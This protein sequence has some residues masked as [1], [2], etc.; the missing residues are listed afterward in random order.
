MG[1]TDEYPVLDVIG[2]GHMGDSN[3]HLNVCTRRYDKAVEKALEPWVYEW[4]SKQNGSI[5]AEHGLGL[6]KKEFIGYSR[7]ETMVRL[8]K[9]LKQLYDPVS[10]FHLLHAVWRSRST[11]CLT[12]RHH[13]PV[14]VHI[15]CDE[16]CR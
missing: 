1:D 3:L 4:V 12:E 15:G 13:E 9:Q 16:K 11:K 5:S 6:A 10:R 8:M 7:S 14:Q 2:Y